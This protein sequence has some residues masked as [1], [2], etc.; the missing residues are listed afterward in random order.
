MPLTFS[1]PALALP[2]YFL[3]KRY[4]SVTGLITGSLAPDFEYFIRM[5]KGPSLYS[6]TIPALFWFNLP[7]ALV[8]A[9]LFHA[10]IK[11]PLLH[12]LP[13]WLYKRFEKYKELKWRSYLTY[14][15]HI[16]IC[17]IL[18]GAA[19]HL[20]WDWFT[21]YSIKFTNGN[22]KIDLEIISRGFYI[23]TYTLIHII[24][25][26]AGLIYLFGLVIQMPYY[27][28]TQIVRQHYGYWTKV[29]I[30]SLIIVYIRKMLGSPMNF[31]DTI[32]SAISA[33]MIAITIISCFFIKKKGEEI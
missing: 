12:N 23:D 32:V 29:L 7:V 1:H 13:Q 4:F 24:F 16:V 11:I 8:L 26:L 21:H 27:N 3:H 18:M 20:L 15:W 19:S 25:S 9:F 22:H 28:T 14:N 31:A 17:S 10:Y 33:I 30:L 2:I 5:K 6:H